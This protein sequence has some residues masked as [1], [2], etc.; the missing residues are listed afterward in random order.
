MENDISNLASQF[1]STLNLPENRYKKPISIAFVGAP[2]SGKS[3]LAYQI[4]NNLP[5]VLVSENSIESFLAEH[6]ELLKEGREAII[7]LAQFVLED[8][9]KSKINSIFD[10]SLKKYSERQ[11]LKSIIESA[12]GQFIVIHI[13]TPQA[14]CFRR[15]QKRNKEI[16]DRS[17]KGTIM[18]WD[19]FFYE[20]NTTEFPRK[21][22]K[23]LS[24]E[25]HRRGEVGRFI[26]RIAKKIEGK[27][28][29]NQ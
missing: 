5:F 3:Y 29:I 17:L 10:A 12:G 26:T 7:N 24:V 16:L 19:Y 20:V 25:A 4:V 18:D 9:T 8:L 28:T 14:T 13:D 15:I 22:E 23:A 21:E 6:S 27:E 11:A 1:I 2:A